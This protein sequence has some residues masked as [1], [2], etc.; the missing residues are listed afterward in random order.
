MRNITSTESRESFIPQTIRG[1]LM[2]HVKVSSAHIAS[3]AYD[4]HSRDMEVKFN[5]GSVYVYH[6]VPPQEH[7]AFLA[8]PSHGQYFHYNI[9]PHYSSEQK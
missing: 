1:N 2:K 4:P 8:S 3:I 7:A 5:N 6:G 9:K